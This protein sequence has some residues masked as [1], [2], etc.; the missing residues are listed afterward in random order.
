MANIFKAPPPLPLAP[1]ILII[2]PAWL[3]DMVMAQSLFLCLKKLYPQCKIDVAAPAPLRAIVERIPE[4]DTFLVLPFA[5]GEFALRKRLSLGR[6]WAGSGYDWAI[7]L[8]NSWKSALPPWAAGIARR[9]GWL[10]EQRY[11]LLNDVRRLDKKSYPLMIERFMALAYSPETIMPQPY[12][13]PKLQYQAVA[14]EEILAT[15]N[16]RPGVPLLVLCPGAAYGPSKRWPAEYFAQVAAEKIAQNWQVILLG[17]AAEQDLAAVIMQQ[18]PGCVNLISK[19]NL[20]QAIDVLSQ[21][22]W[23]ICNDSG[24][25]HIAAALERKSIV[26]YGSSSSEFTPPLS[27]HA[28]IL[29]LQ[30]PC[31]PCHKRICPLQHHNCMRDIKPQMVLDA[32]VS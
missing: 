24:L 15:Y 11:G 27:V 8:P 1:K 9:T 25:M 32:L 12:P 29:K 5:H 23:V 6:S 28:N 22:D 26:V 16:V 7:V 4:V 17:S 13:W 20:S 14:A 31:Q 18:A 10:G 30:L 2:G 3:G 21:A 19:T